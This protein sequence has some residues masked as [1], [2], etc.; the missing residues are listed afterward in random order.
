MIECAECLIAI[1]PIT[2]AHHRELIEIVQAIISIE[3]AAQQYQRFKERLNDK[4]KG[5]TGAER[6]VL[7][8]AYRA[9]RDGISKGPILVST[10]PFL[11]DKKEW[12]LILGK[13]ASA[14]SE[15]F[16][17]GAADGIIEHLVGEIVTEE[18]SPKREQQAEVPAQDGPVVNAGG[19][20]SAP[21]LI[22][23]DYKT[24]MAI[25]GQA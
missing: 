7:R 23:E 12:N 24:A 4:Q 19:S 10:S 17:N 5:L 2:N 18:E 1:M 3:Q 13:I 11:V 15:F 6:N 16:L 22:I 14:R 9:K 25:A 20:D 8:A 21:T